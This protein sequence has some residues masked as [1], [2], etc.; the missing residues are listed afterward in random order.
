MTT[1]ENSAARPILTVS[2]SPH[3]RSS[4]SRLLAGLSFLTDHPVVAATVI[5]DLPVFQPER[6]RAPWPHPVVEWRTAWREASA[7]V[8]STPAYLHSVPAV[9]KNGLEWLTTSGEAAGKPVLTLTFTP[10]PPRGERAMQSLIWSLQALEARIVASLP[11]YQNAVEFT[12]TGDIADGPDREM[13][14]EAL[15]LLA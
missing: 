7:V 15:S 10:H 6:D 12:A 8:V 13:L 14:V 4:N 9:L 1:R 3:P 5:A 2:G 11:L